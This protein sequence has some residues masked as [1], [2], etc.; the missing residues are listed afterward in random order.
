MKVII[1]VFICSLNDIV[2]YYFIEQTIYPNFTKKLLEMK[3]FHFDIFNVVEKEVG[4]TLDRADMQVI[5][6]FIEK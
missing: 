1:I 2:R 6:N 4:G 5:N 3:I